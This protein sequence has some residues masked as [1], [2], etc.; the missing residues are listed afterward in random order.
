MVITVFRRLTWKNRNFNLW[1]VTDLVC[2]SYVLES[3]FIIFSVLKAF[4]SS[5]SVYTWFCLCAISCSM[6]CV[7]RPNRLAIAS[8]KKNRVK[9][10]TLTINNG[11]STFFQVSRVYF[12]IVSLTRS[13][14]FSL[15]IV[16]SFEC[17]IRLLICYENTCICGLLKL[18]SWRIEPNLSYKLLPFTVNITFAKRVSKGSQCAFKFFIGISI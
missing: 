3:P 4:V 15:C 6:V 16:I 13:N 9:P 18:I 17:S 7:S 10:C 2:S 5:K 1:F 8:W 11:K 12:A 14:Y